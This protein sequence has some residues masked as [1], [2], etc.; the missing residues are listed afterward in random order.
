MISIKKS[1]M[2]FL[3]VI[4]LAAG[5][6]LTQAQRQ[7]YRGTTRSVRH[8]ILR[9]ENSTDVFRNTINAQNQT[10]IYTTGGTNLNN[11]VDDL[12]R[13]VVQLRDRFDRRQ[14]TAAD[15]QD[16][17]NRSAL[18]DRFIT[19]RNIRS[20]AV[21]RNWANLSEPQLSEYWLWR[22]SVDRDLSPRSIT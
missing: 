8:L 9:I 10:R 13:A 22:Q 21:L 6:T 18:I 2:A 20:V 3:A 19:D 11:L 16:V 15:A 17:L 12:D 7:T 4:L 14:S 1:L 5:T